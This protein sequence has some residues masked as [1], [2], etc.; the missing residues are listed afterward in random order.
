LRASGTRPIKASSAKELLGP[1]IRTTAIAAGG[2]PDESAKIVSVFWPAIRVDSTELSG[3]NN[4]LRAAEEFHR[5]GNNFQ[6]GSRGV[7]RGVP[8]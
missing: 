8:G 5:L 3:G 4:V 7:L 1:D 6:G 2:R